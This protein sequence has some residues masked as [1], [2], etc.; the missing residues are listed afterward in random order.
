MTT[1]VG[2]GIRPTAQIERAWLADGLL[3]PGSKAFATG[4]LWASGFLQDAAAEL[5]ALGRP[6]RDPLAAL[7]RLLPTDRAAE[8]KKSRL[9]ELLKLAALWI[10]PWLLRQQETFD[11]VFQ[12][13]LRK[14]A[15]DAV[16]QGLDVA[17]YQRR[18]R[19]LVQVF[20]LVKGAAGAWFEA[21]IRQ[22]YGRG[23]DI[24]LAQPDA[25]ELAPWREF[26]TMADDRVRPNHWAL[27]GLVAPA[28]WP[29]W[30]RRYAEPLGYGCRCQTPPVSKARGQRLG[31]QGDFPRGLHF[32][33]RRTVDDPR[34]GRPVL[35]VPGP[36]PLYHRLILDVAA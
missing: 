7:A 25:A 33:E 5:D 4:A 29:L 27:H 19:R 28:G 9:R 3:A 10:T 35:V 6:A 22:P 26:V 34:T 8:D 13:R 15:A 21:M 17:E 20:D 1:A 36:D 2:G 23:R 16:R 32:I 30:D 14:V 24:V 12:E 18:A 11:Q 31:W